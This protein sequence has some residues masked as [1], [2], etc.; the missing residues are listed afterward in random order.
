MAKPHEQE[1]G[2]TVD[3]GR[4]MLEWDS[5]GSCLLTD[6]VTQ[7]DTKLSHEDMRDLRFV[8]GVVSETRKRDLVLRKDPTY[9]GD[10]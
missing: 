6:S 4:W 2:I 8:L 10:K 9:E 5:D 3:R 1:A 7:T